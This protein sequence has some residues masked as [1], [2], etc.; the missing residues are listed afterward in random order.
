MSKDSIKFNELNQALYKLNLEE[1]EDQ[2]IRLRHVWVVLDIIDDMLNHG[3]CF[4]YIRRIEEKYVNPY[5]L[6]DKETKICEKC[7]FL[8]KRCYIYAD[9]LELEDQSDF[10]HYLEEYLERFYYK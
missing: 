8:I 5:S 1:L 10:L 3:S 7:L 2:L 4:E 9:V 6:N